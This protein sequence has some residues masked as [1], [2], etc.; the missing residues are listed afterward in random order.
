MIESDT[1]RFARE[2]NYIA[3][4]IGMQF[5]QF[6]NILDFGIKMMKHDEKTDPL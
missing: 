4:R 5:L 2:K 6:R 1:K 3:R